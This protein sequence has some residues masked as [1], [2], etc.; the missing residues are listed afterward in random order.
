MNEKRRRERRGGVSQGFEGV[1]EAEDEAALVAQIDQHALGGDG[2]ERLV[3][4]V[5][6]HQR[7][8][9]AARQRVAAQER[10]EKRKKERTE[11]TE[12]TREQIERE[13]KEM[14]H[15]VTAES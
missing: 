9:R 2:K 7:L 14:A 13:R 12:R 10:D 4:H 1:E 8:G 11:R 6:H 15:R 5:V 3:V